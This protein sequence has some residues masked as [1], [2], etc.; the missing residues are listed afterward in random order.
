MPY[1][2]LTIGHEKRSTLFYERYAL[3]PAMTGWQ[4]GLHTGSGGN[5]HG[6]GF[7]WSVGGGCIRLFGSPFFHLLR[8]ANPSSRLYGNK[9]ALGGVFVLLAVAVVGCSC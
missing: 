5:E 1:R 8:S 4:G 3:A 9:S 2:R 6:C 7:S